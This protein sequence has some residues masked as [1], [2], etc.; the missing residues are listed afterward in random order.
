MIVATTGVGLTV[1]VNDTGRLIQPSCVFVTWI[2]ET[3]GTFV[4]FVA[5]KAGRLPVPLAAA[6]PIEVLELV[7]LKVP[8]A[9]ELAKVIT[10]ADAPLQ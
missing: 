7:Q 1:M 8:P 9:G 3:I 5:M 10:G 2:L 4:A 6:R